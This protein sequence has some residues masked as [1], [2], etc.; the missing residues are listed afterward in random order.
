M[1]DFHFLVL[2]QLF[3]QDTS[4][5]SNILNIQYPPSLNV[6]STPQGENI[7]FKLCM[8]QCY[9]FS[10]R[11]H[12]F[13]TFFLKIDYSKHLKHQTFERVGA[14]F[15]Y[16]VLSRWHFRPK[17]S[18]IELRESGVKPKV[19]TLLLWQPRPISI[20]INISI[21]VVI[22]FSATL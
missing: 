4:F 12:D 18:V 8:F 7:I 16:I 19:A 21:V 6:H 9:N 17:S 3:I 5:M 13:V 2:I 22:L 14:S 10:G 15:F 1:E 11:H 20:V